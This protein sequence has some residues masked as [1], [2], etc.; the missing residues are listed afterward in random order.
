MTKAAA[1]A[2]VTIL[3]LGL[4]IWATAEAGKTFRGPPEFDFEFEKLAIKEVTINPQRNQLTL[5]VIGVQGMNGR[6]NLTINGAIVKNSTG[7]AVQ[8]IKLENNSVVIPADNSTVTFHFELAPLQSNE[9]CTVT[10]TT[11]T[12]G[13]YVSPTF[14]P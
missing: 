5:T 12:G 11:I 14:T 3:I 6:Q 8:A 4:A 7:S 10:L 2:W 13:S 1:Y 9:Q